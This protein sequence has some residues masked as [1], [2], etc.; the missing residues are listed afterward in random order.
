[1]WLYSIARKKALLHIRSKYAERA[2]LKEV[3][4][5]IP[6]RDSEP[7]LVFEDA[8]QVHYGLNKIS[9]QHREVL[10]LFL[11]RELSIDNISEVLNIPA[12]TVKSRLFY[13]KQ[14]LR[15]VLADEEK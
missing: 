1:V 6:V 12:G 14:A 8:E 10:T 4:N 13:A 3:E 11:L 15:T 9:L 7:N 2:L 5:S